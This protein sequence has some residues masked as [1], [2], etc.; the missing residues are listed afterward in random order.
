MSELDKITKI[1][2]ETS[3]LVRKKECLADFR[4]VFVNIEIIKRFI[5]SEANRENSFERYVAF[6][7]VFKIF[8]MKN[9]DGADDACN[10]LLV[11][12]P[13]TK[14]L[15]ELSELM[16]YAEKQVYSKWRKDT[17]DYINDNF[18]YIFSDESYKMFSIPTLNLIR[19][20]QSEFSSNLYEWIAKKKTFYLIDYFEDFRKTLYKNLETVESMLNAVNITYDS[21]RFKKVIEIIDGFQKVNFK[22]LSDKFVDNLVKQI[23]I[24]DLNEDDYDNTQVLYRYLKKRKHPE[25]KRIKQ[26]LNRSS[27]YSKQLA[28]Q[29]CMLSMNIGFQITN[30][31]IKQPALQQMLSLTHMLY[32]GKWVNCLG[33]SLKEPSGNRSVDL[34]HE[35][36]NLLLDIEESNIANS[37]T[38]KSSQIVNLTIESYLKECIFSAILVDKKAHSV[39]K[40]NVMHFATDIENCLKS[41]DLSR[42]IGMLLKNLDEIGEN[43]PEESIAYNCEFLGCALIEKLLCEVD[44][45]NSDGEL[46]QNKTLSDLLN[47]ENRTIVSLLGKKHIKALSYFL[48]KNIP[49]DSD[50]LGLNIRNSLAHL[51]NIPENQLSLRGIS[52]I[53]WLFTDVLNSVYI[54][55]ILQNKLRRVKEN[56]L[57]R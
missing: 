15:D 56:N 41:K 31:W 24:N 33:Y 47:L 50:D 13:T 1:L 11:M 5:R 42:Y 9:S 49:G 40:E 32:N 6:L 57:D 22:K 37:K 36:N 3:L 38:Y 35:S 27:Q 10:E 4:A 19:E 43:D 26:K 54:Y 21:N 12:Y 51:H 23:E 20:Y 14:S 52:E 34:D 7:L 16:I 55:A 2:S 45:K 30:Y 25:A 48:T 53:V 29:G 8:K 46:L 17:V 44:I 39:W 28:H 18:N